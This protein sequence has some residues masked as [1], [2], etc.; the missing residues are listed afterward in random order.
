M[1]RIPFNIEEAL[2]DPDQTIFS[3]NAREKI[4]ELIRIKELDFYPRGFLSDRRRYGRL[5]SE[6]YLELFV[7]G[8]TMH[9]LRV[10]HDGSHQWYHFDI[11]GYKWPVS[12]GEFIDYCCRRYS[13]SGKQRHPEIFEALLE[14]LELIR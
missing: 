2:K 13:Y 4:K 3:Q 6:K 11:D 9:F 5:D 14:H 1:L 8:G 10:Y 7:G 12:V